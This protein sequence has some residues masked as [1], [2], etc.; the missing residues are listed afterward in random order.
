MKKSGKPGNALKIRQNRSVISEGYLKV[1]AIQIRYNET[2]EASSSKMI[3][4]VHAFI[5]Y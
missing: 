5:T 1:T 4:M 3:D 2:L